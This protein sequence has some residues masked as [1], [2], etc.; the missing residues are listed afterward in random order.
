MLQTLA[1][2]SGGDEAV[3]SHCF[4]HAA[5][6]QSTSVFSFWSESMSGIALT[7][8]ASDDLSQFDLL[9]AY[10]SL[11]GSLARS[12]RRKT[13]CFCLKTGLVAT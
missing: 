2:P 13:V 12:T 11:A 3:S 9:Q 8:R 7:V 1:A 4:A 6:R 5:R 10:P